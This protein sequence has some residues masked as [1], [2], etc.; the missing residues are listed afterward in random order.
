MQESSGIQLKRPSTQTPAA[1]GTEMN[2]VR[3]VCADPTLQQDGVPPSRPHD[4]AKMGEAE[5]REDAS[6]HHNSINETS[7]NEQLQTKPS[8]GGDMGLFLFIPPKPD[9]FHPPDEALWNV[10][11]SVKHVFDPDEMATDWQP[12]TGSD[13]DQAEDIQERCTEVVESGCSSGMHAFSIEQA[14][15]LSQGLSGGPKVIQPSEMQVDKPG[16]LLRAA[17]DGIFSYFLV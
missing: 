10:H 6:E 17:S 7:N 2:G 3:S 12:R 14:E 1:D 8:S 16:S 13:E 11:K 5:K 9:K 15:P 4:V